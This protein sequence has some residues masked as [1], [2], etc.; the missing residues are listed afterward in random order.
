MI[1][2]RIRYEWEKHAQTKRILAIGN[3]RLGREREREREREIEREKE[4]ERE[5]RGVQ[6]GE[7][8]TFMTRNDV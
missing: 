8:G 3:L 7:A 1:L 5:M 2:N 4:R 6:K